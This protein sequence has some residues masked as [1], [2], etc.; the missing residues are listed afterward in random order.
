[1]LTL[2]HMWQ[3]KLVTK[4]KTKEAWDGK[5]KNETGWEDIST[6]DDL[7]IFLTNILNSKEIKEERV[8][9]FFTPKLT[10][11]ELKLVEAKDKA[12]LNSY[13]FHYPDVNPV[14]MKKSDSTDKYVHGRCWRRT[15]SLTLEKNEEQEIEEQEIEEKTKNKKNRCRLIA[16]QCY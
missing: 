16:A 10:E 14:E 3:W 6:N 2:L 8:D 15:Y 7:E 12:H 5:L 4:E 11:E 1:M 13:Y 9:S